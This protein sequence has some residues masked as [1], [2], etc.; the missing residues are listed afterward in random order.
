MEH[1]V[2]T[3]ATVDIQRY[4]DF[5][6]AQVRGEIDTSNI[7]E[8]ADALGAANPSAGSGL[9]V[10]LS[11]VT[12]LNSATVKVLFDLAE[13]LR[14]RQQQLRLV[15]DETAPMRGLMLLLRFDLVMPVHTRLE[16][17]IMEMRAGRTAGGADANVHAD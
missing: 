16:D 12:Y 3:L 14:A 8:V 15:M 7:R 2:N 1:V 4:G 9:V 10:D 5:S 13:G 6:L 11:A 17:A